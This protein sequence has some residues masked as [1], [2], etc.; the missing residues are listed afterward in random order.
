MTSRSFLAPR[1][2]QRA[3][4]SPRIPHGKQVL[5]VRVHDGLEHAKEVA[6]SCAAV[7]I[8]SHD[9]NENHDSKAALQLAYCRSLHERLTSRAKRRVALEAEE[10]RDLVLAEEAGIWRY[11][12]Y[13]SFLEYLERELHY[14]PHAA[15]ERVRVANE[16]F[17]LPALAAKFRAGEVPFTVV[18][19]VTRVAVPETE[20]AWLAATEGKTAREVERLVS[21][22]TKGA[23]P[24]ARP[25][26][27]LVKHRIVL[28]VDGERYAKWRAR[29]TASDDERGERVTDNDL[30]DELVRE[31]S[32]DGTSRPTIH[33][34]TTCRVCK[35]SSFV[36]GGME[37][38]LTE[39]ACER[40]LCDSAEAGDLE[41]DEVIALRTNIAQPTRRRVFIRD[42]FACVVP[43][44]RAGRNLDLH[45]VR[46]QSRGGT[47][48]MSN[49]VVLCS[50][51]HAHLH[52]GRLAITGVAPDRLV[53]VFRRDDDDEPHRVLTSAPVVFDPDDYA[54]EDSVPR[55]TEAVAGS[56]G[57][58]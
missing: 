50:G 32:G 23:S 55:G 49:L 11:F 8:E 31:P 30:V 13:A 9:I 58:R 57:T 20:D 36:A 3:R 26:S 24:G 40:L 4:Q 44:C 19:E 51:H 54:D 47:H 22:L 14:S 53:F 48:A 17:E 12:G 56:P 33:A 46:F 52:D 37:V 18:R 7:A 5:R 41:S 29:R 27:K 25:D 1:R 45:H 34:V 10:A 38:P 6:M 28:E 16:L 2:A 39:A 15:K 21:G 43:G 35:Q 42:R